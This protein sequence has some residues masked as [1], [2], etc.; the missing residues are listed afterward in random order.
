MQIKFY[1]NKETNDSW[2]IDSDG[3]T[4]YYLVPESMYQELKQLIEDSRNK[5]YHIYYN[6]G[7]LQTNV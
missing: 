2:I 5:P 4:K 7:S 3:E 1:H 6:G